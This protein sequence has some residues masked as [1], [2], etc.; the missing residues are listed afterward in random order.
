[1]ALFAG[2]ASCADGVRSCL[3]DGGGPVA[4]IGFIAFAVIGAVVFAVLLNR[5]SRG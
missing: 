3:D 4:I 5:R 2:F 1:M